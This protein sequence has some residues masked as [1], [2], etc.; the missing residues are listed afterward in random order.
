MTAN[1]A[2]NARRLLV[3]VADM[4][5]AFI[6][7]RRPVEGGLVQRL[8]IA[9]SDAAPAFGSA[10]LIRRTPAAA[11]VGTIPRDLAQRTD[12]V[13]S[14]AMRPRL[15]LGGR[16]T[17]NMAAHLEAFTPAQADI[18][19]VRAE[20]IDIIAKLVALHEAEAVVSVLDNRINAVVDQWT[21][22]V[23]R[24][25]VAYEA[26]A[27]H[28]RAEAAA[29][30]AVK[31][32]TL[33]RDVQ[34]MAD[35]ELALVSAEG[36]G[37]RRRAA[38]TYKK[39]LTMHAVS[40][41]QLSLAESANDWYAIESEAAAQLAAIEIRAR[42]AQGEQL[43]QLAR[44]EIAARTQSAND[45]EVGR[46]V[47]ADAV[48]TML[49]TMTEENAVRLLASYRSRDAGAIIQAI[50]ID[51]PQTAAAILQKLSS[52]DAG[53][54]VGYV[55]PVAAASILA[56]IPVHQAVRILTRAAPR[57]AAEVIME[58]PSDISMQIIDAMP[59]RQAATTLAYVRPATVAALFRASDDL[60]SKLLGQLSPSFRDLVNRYLR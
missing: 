18:D 10:E 55:S 22:S 37:A 24:Q 21:N 60:K 8:L 19:Q 23:R 28:R 7:Q 40:E 13:S 6:V 2:G 51:R 14:P 25:L 35:A 57:T 29:W 54:A 33:Q 36:K 42:V 56:S 50:A 4:A 26:D 48:A 46:N 15:R 59:Y 52:H 34:Q 44:L 58:L 1:G 32:A 31:Q 9:L 49:L 16:S 17:E 41:R 3:A 27:T 47:S 5:P 43:K 53:H 45:R 30:L 12:T 11:A 38:R 39:A 20:I